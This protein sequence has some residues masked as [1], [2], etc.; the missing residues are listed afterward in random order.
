MAQN[1]SFLCGPLFLLPRSVASAYGSP[2]KRNEAH[3]GG[4]HHCPG[5]VQ[6]HACTGLYSQQAG[7]GKTCRISPGRQPGQGQN[8]A[9]RICRGCVC[10][11]AGYNGL[12]ECQGIPGDHQHR[13]RAETGNGTWKGHR[14]RDQEFQPGYAGK[15]RPDP[16]LGRRKP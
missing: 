13:F 5:R 4:D 10:A 1:Q 16:D 7:T 15:P 8:R 11:T 2:C 3:R 14:C 12:C 6:L 9:D